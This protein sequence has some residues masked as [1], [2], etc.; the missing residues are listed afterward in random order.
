MSTQSPLQVELRKRVQKMFFHAIMKQ[1]YS[2]YIRIEQKIITREN[3]DIDKRDNSPRKLRTSKY[4]C[5]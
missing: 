5:T 4:V 3:R 1:S 2:G